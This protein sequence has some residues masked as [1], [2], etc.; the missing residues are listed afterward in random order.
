[1]ASQGKY[2]IDMCRGPLLGKMLLFVL[3]IFC[4]YAL[5]TL[6]NAADMVIIGRMIDSECVS[7]TRGKKL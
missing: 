3:P 2:D 6:F 5:Q 1:M 7:C 4:T